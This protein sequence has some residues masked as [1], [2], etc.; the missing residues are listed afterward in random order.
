MGLSS[1]IRRVLNERRL[2]MPWCTGLFATV[3]TATLFGSLGGQ[4]WILVWILPAS[5]AA[6]WL[7]AYYMWYVYY[8]AK[9]FSDPLAPS[10]AVDDDK[11]DV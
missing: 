1:Q 10:K 6:G 8:A 2:F 4:T 7:F 9:H 11:G 5:L 3:L